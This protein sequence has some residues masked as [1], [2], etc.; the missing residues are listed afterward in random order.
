M[1]ERQLDYAG[2]QIYHKH[3]TPAETHKLEVMRAF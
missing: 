1:I 2:R 3:M